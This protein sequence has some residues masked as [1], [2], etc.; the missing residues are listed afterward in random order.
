M[1]HSLNQL[2]FRHNFKELILCIHYICLSYVNPN[3]ILQAEFIFQF[4]YVKVKNELHLKKYRCI[5]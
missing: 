1:Q 3:N 4:C 5:P 2:I